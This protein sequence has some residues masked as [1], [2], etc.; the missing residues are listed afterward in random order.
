MNVARIFEDV[1]GFYVCSEDGPLDTSGRAYKKK[2]SAIRAA[3]KAGFTHATGS[4]TY[5]GNSIQR[6]PDHFRVDSMFEGGDK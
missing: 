2:A 3:Y 6:I 1:G 5:W 4:G